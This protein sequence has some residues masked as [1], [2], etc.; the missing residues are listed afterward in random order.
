MWLR[1]KCLKVKWPE[2]NKNLTEPYNGHFENLTEPYTT[3]LPG[4]GHPDIGAELLILKQCTQL[5]DIL[6]LI[7]F[8]AGIS[9]KKI[10]G[11]AQHTKI[12]II[13]KIYF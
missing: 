5:P 11:E 12:K 7:N 1:Q 10:Y 13:S 6:E 3:P 4:C 8:E 9:E 2:N